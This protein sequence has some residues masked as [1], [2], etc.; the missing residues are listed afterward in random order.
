MPKTILSPLTKAT[1]ASLVA[2]WEWGDSLWVT[3]KADAGAI[4]N[5]GVIAGR[6]FQMIEAKH[7]TDRRHG[8][9]ILCLK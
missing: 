6:R 7:P 4:W 5:A 2:S 8:W 9:L 3:R 1:A